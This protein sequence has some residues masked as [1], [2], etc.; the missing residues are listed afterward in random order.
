MAFRSADVEWQGNAQSGHGHIK[1]ASGAF[2]GDYS[3]RTRLN[4]GAETNPEEQLASALAGCFT[5]ACSLA[6][7]A[8]GHEPVRI[9][10]TAQVRLTQRDGEYVI[11]RIDLKMEAVVPGI[12]AATFQ[13]IATRAKRSCPVSK[14]LA[15]TEILLE[16]T[17]LEA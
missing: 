9:H 10:T 2:E 17:L 1:L 11:P 16:T 4:G 13:E 15:G 3:L 5:M 6:L 12:D 14:A 8:A 7:G